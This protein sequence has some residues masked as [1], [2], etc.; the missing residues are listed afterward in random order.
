MSGMKARIKAKAEQYRREYPGS[1]QFWE[2]LREDVEY[3]LIPHPD[4]LKAAV[5]SGR[6]I[7]PWALPYVAG[8]VKRPRGCSTSWSVVGL[9]FGEALQKAKHSEFTLEMNAF[10]RRMLAALVFDYERQY[11]EDPDRRRD[12]EKQH[13]RRLGRILHPQTPYAEALATVAKLAKLDVGT[14]A[15]YCRTYRVMGNR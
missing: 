3:G 1:S 15:S 4:A 9:S 2:D 13:R 10:H 12:Q 7:A 14:I 8:T 6:P 5:L 11:R